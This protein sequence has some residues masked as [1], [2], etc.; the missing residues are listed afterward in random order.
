MI[1]KYTLFSILMFITSL[2]LVAQ[3]CGSTQ[4][5][6]FAGPEFNGVLSGQD[7]VM[8]GMRIGFGAG[9]DVSKFLSCNVAFATGLNYNYAPF[10]M[11]T[12]KDAEG[13]QYQMNRS[14][15]L[16]IPLGIKYMTDQNS[17]STSYYFGLSYINALALSSEMKKTK[18]E[19]PTAFDLK[20]VEGTYMLYNPGAKIELGLMNKFDGDNAF[21]VSMFFKSI[22]HNYFSGTESDKLTTF[23]TGLNV[24][25][26]F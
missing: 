4:F 21:T 13:Y 12:N 1:Q 19:K 15:V 6:I 25:Y 18:E 20:Y 22:F 16:E 3:E 26:V 10:E 11:W 9:L 17:K 23:G 7:K 8:R 14:H 5:R 24:G 2:N